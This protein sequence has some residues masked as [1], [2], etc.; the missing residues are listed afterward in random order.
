MNQVETKHTG[1]QL[2][3]VNLFKSKNLIVEIP[4]IQRDYAQ[5]RKNKSRIRDKFL[6]SL[7]ES[8]ESDVN[9]DLDFVYGS[10][11]E[12]IDGLNKFI[13]LDGQQRLTTLFLLHWFLAHKDSQIEL[14]NDLLLKEKKSR[15]TYKTRTSSTEFCDA[16]V[17]NDFNLH[18]LLVGDEY[19]N[20]RLSET[21]RNSTWYFLSWDNDPTV[22]G[23]LVMLD[24]IHLKF[25]NS[26]GFFDKL[27]D[28]NKPVITFQ[29]LNLKHLKMTDD[30]YI[31]MNARGKELTSFENFKAQFEGFLEKAF[32]DR[33]HCFSQKIDGDWSD[34]FWDMAVNHPEKPSYEIDNHIL[35]YIQY[36]T[37][38][39]FHRG[40]TTEFTEFDFNNFSIVEEVYRNETNLLFL[41]HS[42]EL[43][44]YPTGKEYR[45][46]ID[47]FFK[48]VFSFEFEEGK[49]SLFDKNV[50]LFEK[51]I[52][53]SSDIDHQDKLLLFAIL[54]YLI[55]KEETELK[56]S[57]N[58]KDYVRVCRNF[59][60][61]I[62]QKGNSKKKNEFVPN[63]RASSYSSIL[64]ALAT[65]FDK[66]DVYLALPNK[67]TLISQRRDNF[68]DEIFKAKCINGD[69]NFK[70][71]IHKLEDHIHLKGDIHNFNLSQ[72][73][74]KSFAA[75]VSNFY[76]VFAN[77]EDGLI[78]R[79]LLSIGDYS[80]KIGNCYFGEL[81][82]FGNRDKWNRVLV[83][84]ENSTKLQGIFLK[85]FEDIND[86][87]DIQLNEKLEILIQKG[88][89]VSER[90]EWEKLFLKYPLITK[91][92]T[93]IYSFN[94]TKYEI[95]LLS[96]TSLRS[97]HI[98][99]FIK[100]VIESKKVTSELSKS[101]CWSKDTYPSMILVKGS[102]Y[103]FQYN[104]YWHIHAKSEDMSELIDLFDLQQIEKDNEYKLYSSKDKDFVEIAI[105]FINQ[106]Y[107]L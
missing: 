20:S 73:N 27:L 36:I 48:N 94:H 61:K 85:Y 90:P 93:S 96:G 66:T 62:N 59:I 55:E 24:A 107:E 30:L 39:L 81:R 83:D 80:V 38:M 67:E 50:N 99:S 37:E 77:V 54:H 49:V 7:F 45:S 88:I 47:A 4:I 98:N 68:S 104:D 97:L 103:M 89:D 52:Y 11:S 32:P 13:P 28:D 18:N 31:K 17:F 35:K 6:N 29:F 1:E 75:L 9:I 91:S 86:L 15:F 40:N 10:I 58:L 64:I 34:L 100:A 2:A 26:N 14:L 95:E 44:T 87:G 92:E 79:S 41:T 33:V 60:L 8:L 102:I 12:E 106:F 63:I 3:F 22:K 76:D 69:A 42:F 105:D 74:I 21:I 56:V 57:D 84:K 70:K 25:Q 51:L 101:A 71:L 78:I 65:M 72:A 43:F 53:S 16:L 5:G 46:N 19:Q 82:F 23:M